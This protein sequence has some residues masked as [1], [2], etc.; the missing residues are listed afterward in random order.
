MIHVD[1]SWSCTIITLHT[2]MPQDPLFCLLIFKQTYD[3]Q[4]VQQYYGKDSP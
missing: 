2:C 1:I 3:F 4:I